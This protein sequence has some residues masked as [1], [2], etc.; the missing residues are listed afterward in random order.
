MCR[1]LGL[2][3]TLKELTDAGVLTHFAGGVDDV[4]SIAGENH[5]VAA[6]YR[7]GAIHHFVDRAIVEVALFAADRRTIDDDRET[8]LA[9]AQAEALRI[10]DLLKF[11]FFFPTKQE[12]LHR[13]G[14]EMDL[15]APEW[16]T[17]RPTPAWLHDTFVAMSGE[18]FARR[19]L[20]PFFDAQLV[21]SRRLV[22]LGEE[23]REKQEIIADCLGLGKQLALQGV[24]KSR[25]SVSTELYTAAYKLA[26]NRGLIDP[27]DGR[28]LV[29]ARQEWLDEVKDMRDRLARIAEIEAKQTGVTAV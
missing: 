5:A 1:G 9:A 18:L 3:S 24:V 28:D 22:E 4:W 20:Q 29:A 2:K 21:M 14:A 26:D 27:Y 8:R 7:N 15:I 23:S 11:E 10:R 16:R 25:D 17:V 12:F 6:Y 19:T 13:L